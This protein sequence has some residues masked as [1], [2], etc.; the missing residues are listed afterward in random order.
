[1]LRRYDL[2]TRAELKSANRGCPGVPRCPVA[3]HV[4]TL[5]AAGLSLLHVRDLHVQPDD[6]GG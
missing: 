6:D 4:P 2:G 5:V 1:M 3:V